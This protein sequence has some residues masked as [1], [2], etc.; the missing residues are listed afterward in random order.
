MRKKGVRK[1]LVERVKEIYQEVK[2][3]VKV[4][5]EITTEFWT[6]KGVRQSCCLNL[7]LFSLYILDLEEMLLKTVGTGIRVAKASAHWPMRMIW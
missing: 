6:K 4:G 5:E 3:V 1:K 7:M 2:N